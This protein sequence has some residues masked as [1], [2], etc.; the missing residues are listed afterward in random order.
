M[1]EQHVDAMLEELSGGGVLAARGEFALD[2]SKAREKLSKFQLQNPLAYVLEFIQASYLLGAT[3]IEVTVD[4]DEFELRWQGEPL[5]ASALESLYSAAFSRQ[6]DRDLQSLK[7]LAI[8]VNAASA[9]NL[10]RLIIEGV[11]ADG[12]AYRW[13]QIG[14]VEQIEF[15]KRD[16]RDGRTPG[17][18]RIYLKE[19][20]RLA[21]IGEFFGRLRREVAE[22]DLIK[23]R[24]LYSP[25]EIVINGQLF[26]HERVLP[27]TC[28]ASTRFAAD[29]IS[30]VAGLTEGTGVLEMQVT[31][32]GVLVGDV[33]KF[34]SVVSGHVIVNADHLQKDLS[35]A[36]LVE[37]EA[38]RALVSGLIPDIMHGLA[39]SHLSEVLD[40]DLSMTR[41]K[42]DVLGTWMEELLGR[43]L[44][45][46]CVDIDEGVAWTQSFEA[47]YQ[48][49]RRV[50][51]VTL[52]HPHEA[53]DL[54][55]GVS[56]QRSIEEV[57]RVLRRQGMLAVSYSTEIFPSVMHAQPVF[58]EQPV[59]ESSSQAHIS[60]RD[61]LNEQGV[62]GLIGKLEQAKVQDLTQALNAVHRRQKNKAILQARPPLSDFEE[63]RGSRVHVHKT[64]GDVRYTWSWDGTE[65]APQIIYVREGR[66]FASHTLP[67]HPC[68]AGVQ[69]MIEGPFN[70]N[71]V[72]SDVLKDAA[73]LEVL[74]T[75]ALAQFPKF[76]IKRAEWLERMGLLHQHHAFIEAYLVELCSGTL[77]ESLLSTFHASDHTRKVLDRLTRFLNHE[78]WR[79]IDRLNDV[80]VPG[81]RLALF[82]RL[83]A[84]AKASLYRAVEVGTT[85]T[86]HLNLEDLDEL[87]VDEGSLGFVTSRFDLPKLM[88]LQRKRPV[89]V[90]DDVGRE[91]LAAVVSQY[92]LRDVSGDLIKELARA[93]FMKRAPV[94]EMSTRW[95]DA[96][97]RIESE[98]ASVPYKASL[99]PVRTLQQALDAS[100]MSFGDKVEILPES[101]LTIAGE[102][103]LGGRATG[104][105]QVQF[106]YNGRELEVSGTRKGIG[107]LKMQVDT[108]SMTI[109]E[110]YSSL[111]DRTLFFRLMIQA[112]QESW[113]MVNARLDTL[114][115]RIDA[116]TDPETRELWGYMSR[117]LHDP[118]L[119]S[120]DARAFAARIKH[121]RVFMLRTTG[122]RLT[123]DELVECEDYRGRLH[124]VYQDQE[125]HEAL[126]PGGKGRVVEIPS[127]A[128]LTQFI[129]LLGEGVEL[130]HVAR[131]DEALARV[132]Q[133]RAEFFARA[134]LPWSEP[135]GTHTRE[136]VWSRDFKV[137]TRRGS[138]GM[139]LD[140][141]PHDS[142]PGIQIEL[143]HQQR[144]I[145]TA[146]RL[147]YIGRFAVRIE[148]DD[149]DVDPSWDR[150][151]NT[152]PFQ[153]LCTEITRKVTEGLEAELEEIYQHP[154]GLTPRERQM[155]M[156]YILVMEASKPR[157]LE[158]A[159]LKQL[160]EALPLFLRADG[161][162]CAAG[163]VRE[164][165]M[166]QS[167][168]L[169]YIDSP[170]FGVP[171]EWI[172]NTFIL[173]E[174]ERD[175]WRDLFDR[176][177]LA[178]LGK[179]LESLER[180][181][182][183][184]SRIKNGVSQS[185]RVLPSPVEQEDVH[186]PSNPTESE[187]SS[188]EPALDSVDLVPVTPMPVASAID[189]SL[190]EQ[191][192]EAPH[193]IFHAKV[194][195]ELRQRLLANHD[196]EHEL[197]HIQ[198]DLVRHIEFG[199]VSAPS[200]VVIAHRGV[201]IDRSHVALRAL[202]AQPDEEMWWDV[203]V[204][205]VYSA[206]NAHYK[207]ITDEH[208]ELFLHE[209]SQKI[210]SHE[211]H[212]S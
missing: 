44:I 35:R 135:P 99:W 158:D 207:A 24:C 185:N 107:R 204:S 84:L 28:V 168:K 152:T 209:L 186:S 89:L 55:Y 160:I 25:Q 2:A 87:C 126:L 72:Y 49:A 51:C 148:A 130:V 180:Q 32:H 101:E 12:K 18:M 109:N 187:H 75:T 199:E 69:L 192:L 178:D 128:F 70:P 97:D 76:M 53:F 68:C 151:A 59:P 5:E 117:I 142:V 177:I 123:H 93:T 133:A 30:G 82:R 150:L 122:R 138:M 120:L 50:P 174:G 100:N 162:W 112:K 83:G 17:D 167:S 154:P 183:A 157:D 139:W 13:T 176:A 85:L 106:L 211:R 36:A 40:V 54:Q 71:A 63:P 74:A 90:L 11:D 79:L 104:S 102:T 48:I 205:S 164:V 33:Q 39:A 165:A 119:D 8:G 77:F 34:R 31:Q 156:A 73:H 125:V 110:D 134:E 200:R 140:K 105:V 190:P 67:P 15:I 210:L 20:L 43:S 78:H 203:L 118:T 91:R 92:V 27:E 131:T 3:R 88:H 143:L 145:Q 10:S 9:L 161:V 96:L 21:H 1:T 116:L 37:D 7:H 196:R 137:G 184:F 201:I 159:S 16:D 6:F 179:K 194:L 52:A 141:T 45:A 181:R 146:T 144:R 172:S 108:T 182:V 132:E 58:L 38:W 153:V 66:M 23:A 95:G 191:E 65:N 19:R 113:R 124:Y 195:V 94:V 193:L 62:A 189:P 86:M 173:P 163:M 202:T 26:E 206:T 14:E 111:K 47:L 171:E 188:V 4:S 42:A 56:H 80:A 169:Y 212:Q 60:W 64:V 127:G 208:E 46:R 57:V 129:R 121:I 41:V 155:W 166:R 149:L 22:V 198:D 81:Q 170:D 115:E 98:V 197:M 136:F 103:F 147:M 175:V 61:D 114:L 29:H